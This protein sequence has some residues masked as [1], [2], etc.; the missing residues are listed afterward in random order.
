MAKGAD[1]MTIDDRLNEFE[2]TIVNLTKYNKVKGYDPD[3]LAQDLRMLLIH[4]VEHFDPTRNV[5]FKTYFI[6]SSLNY[7]YKMQKKY[8]NY[9]SNQIDIIGQNKNSS[10]EEALDSYYIRDI[11]EDYLSLI[12][13]ILDRLKKLPQGNITLEYYFD[14]M[15]QQQLAEKYKIS[16]VMVHKILQNNLAELKKFAKEL[17]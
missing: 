6:K 12:P 2:K 7:I 3:D 10:F 17:I 13:D 1:N 5:K 4:C 11:E 8:Y 14:N 9:Y 16:Q 15:T